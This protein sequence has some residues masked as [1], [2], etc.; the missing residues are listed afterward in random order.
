[1]GALASIVI[2]IFFLLLLAI[3]VIIK[4]KKQLTPYSTNNQPQ[5]VIVQSNG[6]G[7]AGFVFALFAVFLGWIPVLGWILWFFGLFFSFLG[8][9]KS[10][11]GLAIVGFILSLI[12]LILLLFVVTSIAALFLSPSLSTNSNRSELESK[13]SY[14]DT[15]AVNQQNE[16]YDDSSKN[17]ESSIEKTLTKLVQEWNQGHL[18]KNMDTFSNMFA[19]S[20][21]FY[22]KQQSLNGCLESKVSLFKRYPDFNQQIYGAIDIVEL[23]R[24]EYKCYFTKSVFVNQKTTDYPSYLIFRNNNGEWKIIAESDL[25]TDKNLSKKKLLKTSTYNNRNYSYEPEISVISGVIIV[26]CFLGPPGY[27]DNPET[28]SREYSYVLMLEKPIDIIAK[29]ENKGEGNLD[30]IKSNIKEIQLTTTQK[31]NLSNYKNKA[32]RLT[33]TFFEADNGH[34]HTDV[35]IDVQQIEEL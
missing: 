25:V 33:G 20:V 17:N 8:L 28:D 32:V 11:R 34:H 31:I 15:I 2:I 29:T 26:V 22:G 12:D 21:S 6:F 4:N 19:N 35:L 16:I 9:F 24:D 13:K 3:I 1:M 7:T 18:S 23:T 14:N 30:I 10:P 5:Q 27:G